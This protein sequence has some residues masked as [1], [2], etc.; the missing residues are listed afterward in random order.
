MAMRSQSGQ[1]EVQSWRQQWS[2]LVRGLVLPNIQDNFLAPIS[3]PLVGSETIK[4]SDSW[5]AP[6]SRLF[7]GYRRKDC[8]LCWTVQRIINAWSCL[9]RADAFFSC[10]AAWWVKLCRNSFYLHSG[11]GNVKFDRFVSRDQPPPVLERRRAVRQVANLLR[12][13][14]FTENFNCTW[15]SLQLWCRWNANFTLPGQTPIPKISPL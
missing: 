6:W 11:K 12:S 5:S 13:S 3:I 1:F 7:A 15:D 4:M 9:A 10:P 2:Y 8:L 14:F